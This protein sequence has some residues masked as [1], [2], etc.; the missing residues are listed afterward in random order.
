MNDDLKSKVLDLNKIVDY[1][2]GTIVSKTI[3]NKQ[4][5]TI[6]LFAFD[7]GQ[8]LSEHSA[9]F[10]AILTV[11]DGEAEITI[12]GEVFHL[13]AGE[14]IIMPANDPH[15]V[16]AIKQFKMMLTMIKWCLPMIVCLLVK[17]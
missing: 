10:D 9:P 4:T 17:R 11:L 5:G 3:I 7:E 2:E 12:T 6:T 13:N 8:G 16:R 15:A 14:M 1:Q